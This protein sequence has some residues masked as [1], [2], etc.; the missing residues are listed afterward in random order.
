MIGEWG[1][2][3]GSA[4]RYSSEQTWEAG[5][6]M[7]GGGKDSAVFLPPS[8][9]SDLEEDVACAIPE[10]ATFEPPRTCVI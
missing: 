2:G 4:T 3:Y 1:R 6:G 8:V 7:D 10:S 5:A 9:S